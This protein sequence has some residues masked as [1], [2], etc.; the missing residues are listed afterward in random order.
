LARLLV[1]HDPAGKSMP[2]IATRRRQRP[3][4]ELLK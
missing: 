3:D 2:T 1:S 4:A